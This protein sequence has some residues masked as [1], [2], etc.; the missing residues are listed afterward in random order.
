MGD[1]VQFPQG[2][3]EGEAP[4][5]GYCMSCGTEVSYP[6]DLSGWPE[7]CPQGCAPFSVQSW[8]PNR[9]SWV[10]LTGGTMI[11]GTST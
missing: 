9:V 4:G 1:V 3:P 10:E 8:K 6:N 5:V 11:S 7:S 2:E